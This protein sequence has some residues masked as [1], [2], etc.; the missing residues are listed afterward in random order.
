[1]KTNNEDVKRDIQLPVKRDDNN[2]DDI[3][4]LSIRQEKHKSITKSCKETNE[5]EIQYETNKSTEDILLEKERE[6]ISLSEESEKRLL[7]EDKEEKSPKKGREE[8]LFEVLL[9]KQSEEISLNEKIGK[10]L[11]EEKIDRSLDKTNEEISIS[12]IMEKE[13]IS[14]NKER[15]IKS[16]DR[17]RK[18]IS[19]NKKS[20]EKSKRKKGKARSLSKEREKRPSN[21]ISINKSLEKENKFETSEDLQPTLTKMIP[22]TEMDLIRK[23]L[24]NDDPVDDIDI[25]SYPDEEEG[26]ENKKRKRTQINK[27]FVDFLSEDEDF[28]WDSSSWKD[29]GESSS[30]EDDQPKKRKRLQEGKVGEEGVRKKKINKRKQKQTSR[31]KGKGLVKK[32]GSISCEKQLHPNPCTGK[33]CGHKCGEISEAKRNNLFDHFWSLSA[34]RKRNWLVAMTT[35][36]EVSRKRNK[37]S[38]YRT[39]TYQYFINDG[40]G[41]R[42][43]CLQ[44]LLKTLDVTQR[45]VYYTMTNA[46]FNLGSAKNDLRGKCV[47]VNKT[48][49]EVKRNATDFFKSLPALP[50]HYCRK[51]STKLYLP[52]EFKNIKNLYRIYKEDRVSKGMNVVG[53][54]VFRNIFNKEF[55]LGFHVPKKDKCLKCLK[56]EGRA[57]V[58][59]EIITHL[60]EKEASKRR[61]QVHRELVKQNPAIIC[62]SF[63]LQ[64][65]LN[66]PH[67]NS[68]LLFYSR[69]YAVYNLCF[70]ES[71]TR[72]GFCYI[73]GETQGKR[74]G[75]EIA[76]ILQKYI[77]DV[78]N[79]KS[80]KILI[81]Y[82]DSCPGQNKNRI[83]LAAIHNALLMS[84]N[85]ETIQ[86]NYLLPGHTEMTVDSIHST[87]ESSVRN[88]IVWAPS[89][90]LTVCQLARKEPKPYQVETLS[91]VDFKNFEDLSDKYFKGNLQGKVSK[92]RIAT[93]KKSTPNI[94]TV[95]YSM[96][97]DA[98]EETIAII[99]KPKLLS[100]KYKSS[101]PIT[102]TKYKDLKKLCDTNV[103]KSVFHAEYINLPTHNGKDTLIDTDIEDIDDDNL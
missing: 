95:K 54:K 53:E 98:A 26:T 75:D 100:A 34:E 36:K 82:S 84:E 86:M 62:T 45:Y 46:D 12:D 61:L 93:F 37:D 79:R 35:K 44:F 13:E 23:S 4:D 9:E 77:A 40:E 38:S 49:E 60:E 63:D 64:K 97:N 51:D 74:G 17:E 101:L 55:N 28:V 76:T 50:S 85:L 68:M 41:R 5:Y 30:S 39:N 47:P 14:L 96:S 27:S 90:W 78:D 11:L 3:A 22:E 43:V 10:R 8:I 2:C 24:E 73:W 58:E 20:K 88:T 72:N 99:P 71:V 102:K 21:N 67:G 65:V 1:M 94:L 6:E 33:N 69:K 57:K 19:E 103:I 66:T 25:P 29:T 83:V 42:Q 87:I 15:E 80:V 81:L 92:I 48:S 31:E 18:E 32:N 52:T 16:L 56:Y 89:Q 7:E 59:P 91:H 70:Y